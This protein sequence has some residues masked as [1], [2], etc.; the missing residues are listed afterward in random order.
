ME[1]LNKLMHQP[2]TRAEIENEIAILNTHIPNSEGKLKE[3][4]ELK[5]NELE[6]QLALFTNVSDDDIVEVVD[7]SSHRTFERDTFDV[8]D[9]DIVSVKPPRT[10]NEILAERKAKSPLFTSSLYRE[11]LEVDSEPAHPMQAAIFGI[12]GIY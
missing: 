3:E 5:R 1:N 7:T 9:M 11:K 6:K 4:R 8:G 10:A 2:M 12:K